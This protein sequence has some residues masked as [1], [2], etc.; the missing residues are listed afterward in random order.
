MIDGVDELPKSQRASFWEWLSKFVVDYPDN[1]VIVTSRTLPGSTKIER[2]ENLSEWNPPD[3]FVDAHLEEMTNADLPMAI[4]RCR[5]SPQLRPA[6]GRVR[7]RQE[8]RPRS[9]LHW[10]G[11][12][13]LFRSPRRQAA[14]DQKR[15]QDGKK[16]SQFQFVHHASLRRPAC[17]GINVLRSNPGGLGLSGLSKWSILDRLILSMRARFSAV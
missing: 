5:S 7:R 13:R 6:V 10:A 12:R 15:D 8:I 1:R 16:D 11:V 4:G 9:I 14:Y 3:E 2:P 17:G